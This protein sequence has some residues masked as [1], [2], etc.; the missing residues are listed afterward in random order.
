MTA[1]DEVLSGYHEANRLAV[2]IDRLLIAG[3]HIANWRKDSWPGYQLDGLTRE[4]QCENALR[5]LGATQ[6]YDT[7]VC[8]S[9]MMQARDDYVNGR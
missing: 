9:G 3:N 6:E 7:W 8:W 2:I 4:Q 5:K 1:L